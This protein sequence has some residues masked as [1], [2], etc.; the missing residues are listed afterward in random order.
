MTNYSTTI[1]TG[2]SIVLVIAVGFICCKLKLIPE[3]NFQV[4][5][6]FVARVAFFFLTFRTLCGKDIRDLNWEPFGVSVLMI[7]TVYLLVAFMMLYPVKDR[8]GTYL[9]TVFPTVYVNYTVTGIV[10]FLSIWDESDIGVVTVILISDDLI[11]SPLFLML[12][13]VRNIVI[14]NQALRAKGEEPEC[15]AKFLL[16]ILS[17]IAKNMFLMGILFGLIYSSFPLPTCTFLDEL[18][19]LLGDCVLALA[20]F[21]VGAFLSQQSVMACPWQ[22]FLISVIVRLIVCPLV[23]IAYC[24]ALKLPGKMS[25]QC[26]ILSAQPTAVACYSMSL[27]A[28][29]GKEVATTMTLWTSVLMVPSIIFW[30]FIL[31]TFHMF[32]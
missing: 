21:N 7:I 27:V 26:T 9:S 10:M 16:V 32:E 11:A 3:K 14:Q 24:Y 18:N 20:L 23:T 30:L 28:G 19:K 2:I 29:I 17:H 4:L 1:H 15:S 13:S 22:Q 8:F 5:N 12:A 6:L 25:R 31:D